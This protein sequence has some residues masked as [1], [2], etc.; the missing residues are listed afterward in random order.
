M[1]IWDFFVKVNGTTLDSMGF[2]PSTLEGNWDGPSLRVDE[3]V[4]P[5][6][7][8]TVET[9]HEETLDPLDLT[10][11]GELQGTS[12]QDFEDKLDA[13]KLALYRALITIIVGNQDARQRTGRV[14]GVKVSMGQSEFDTGLVAIRIHCANPRLYATSTT[15]VTGAAATDL[16]VAQGTARTYP[17]I[18]LTSATNPV[19]TYKNYAGATVATLTVTG[20]GTIIIDCNPVTGRT[21]TIDG[22]RS[23]D[24]LSAGDFFAISPVDGTP[25]LSQWP[26]IRSSSG[27]VSIAYR[28]AYL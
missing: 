23:D 10:I 7:E 16:A 22:V 27:S 21:I 24:A 20:S 17:V 25:S 15:T 19:I 28:K 4:I 14:V 12:E 26:T 8:G 13:L 5:G 18:T 9:T 11:T 3:I 1:A 2:K 6:A